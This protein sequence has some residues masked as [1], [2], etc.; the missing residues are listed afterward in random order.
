MTVRKRLGVGSVSFCLL[1]M[2]VRPARAFGEP[3]RHDSL[4]I[5]GE[6]VVGPHWLSYESP[7][8]TGQA[9]EGEATA[10]TFGLFASVGWTLPAGLVLGGTFFAH[11]Q[12]NPDF[13]NPAVKQGWEH[14]TGSLAG[15]AAFGRFYPNPRRGL[16]FEGM[17][18]LAHYQIRQTRS[19]GVNLACPPIF[20]DCLNDQPP[21]IEIEDKS[22]GYLLG[23]GA[24]YELWLSGHFSLG[25]TARVNYA[26]TW[27]GERSYT[28]WMPMVGLGATW[29]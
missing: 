6:L 20:P 25:L 11:V 10:K 3:S 21:S 27:A 9:H 4:Y 7:I 5:H 16:H 24:G 2:L 14:T 18:G 13:E 17:A 12:S 1:V 26:H 15:L 29:N 28:L 8:N 22:N 23:G 19:G